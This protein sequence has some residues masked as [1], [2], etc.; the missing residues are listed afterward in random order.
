M[1]NLN[2]SNADNF[3]IINLIVGLRFCFWWFD[4][5]LT[6]LPCYLIITSLTNDPQIKL[7]PFI[8]YSHSDSERFRFQFQSPSILELQRIWTQVSIQIPTKYYLNPIRETKTESKTKSI[9]S[10]FKS[11]KIIEKNEMKFSKKIRSFV[12]VDWNI[13]P[14]LKL[15]IVIINV[16]LLTFF[17]SNK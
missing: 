14:S 17:L 13:F 9:H 1:K 6:L 2:L 4:T 5:I 11:Q 16:F 7:P 12:L 15:V 3:M 10:K 8:Y